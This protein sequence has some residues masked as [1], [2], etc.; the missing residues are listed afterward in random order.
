MG[1]NEMLPVTFYWA[2]YEGD[3][4][5]VALFAF[6]RRGEAEAFAVGWENH[7]AIYPAVIQGS[8]VVKQP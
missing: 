6:D 1:L 4:E 2:V 5:L 7:Y 3:T 8:V